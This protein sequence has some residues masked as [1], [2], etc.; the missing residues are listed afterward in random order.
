MDFLKMML[1]LSLILIVGCGSMQQDEEAHVKRYS[2]E[3]YKIIPLP[4]S[5]NEAYVICR[6]NPTL[7]KG[8]FY[9]TKPEGDLTGKNALNDETFDPCADVVLSNE[10]SS[11]NT[12]EMIVAGV[13]LNLRNYPGLSEALI[14]VLAAGETVLVHNENYDKTWALVEAKKDGLC[15][16]VSKQYLSKP[17]VL[18][19]DARVLVHTTQGEKIIL[20]QGRSVAEALENCQKFV[21]LQGYYVTVYPQYGD[22]KINSKDPAVI[23]RALLPI[24]IS[25]K[26][27]KYTYAKKLVVH[28]SSS[29]ERMIILYGDT[30]AQVVENCSWQ[31]NFF[32]TVYPAYSDIQINSN[33]YATVCSK[34]LTLL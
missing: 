32:V 23:C 16:W 30:L 28:T 21:G 5:P 29:G 17:N 20:I 24:V 14:R 33:N 3:I 6:S 10:C 7:L 27:L 34:L 12:E 31:V 19:V 11:S 1:W 18:V 4:G 26:N 15:G 8:S 13:G 2:S 9:F 25:T 22:L